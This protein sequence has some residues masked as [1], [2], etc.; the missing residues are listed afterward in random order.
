[1]AE[2]IKH[3]KSNN[4]I[5]DDL[6]DLRL[7]SYHVDS[8]ADTESKLI[9]KAFGVENNKLKSKQI[10]FFFSEYLYKTKE[11]IADST[12]DKMRDYFRTIRHDVKVALD[13]PEILQT[14]E[15]FIDVLDR[16]ADYD[17]KILLPRFKKLKKL[18]S[19]YDIL[20][21]FTLTLFHNFFWRDITEGVDKGSGT[22]NLSFV[23]KQI[24]P[25][26]I[27]LKHDLEDKIN[28]EFKMDAHEISLFKLSILFSIVL[29]SARILLIKSKETFLISKILLYNLLI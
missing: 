21:S 12:A 14:L 22:K 19:M 20:I 15:D 27:K 26:I 2:K 10:P 8:K 1:M 16:P 24:L 3:Q 28:E 9:T 6:V 29:I 25:I 7:R 13:I 4:E 11:F 17:K 5:K 18:E 23:I